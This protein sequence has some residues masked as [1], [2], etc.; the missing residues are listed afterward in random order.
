MKVK[1][2]STTISLKRGSEDYIIQQLLGELENK[3]NDAI[4]QLKSSGNNIQSIDHRIVY[5]PPVVHSPEKLV[6]SAQI[7]YEARK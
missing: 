4:T 6:A 1:Y 3:V 2:I 7:I 5:I